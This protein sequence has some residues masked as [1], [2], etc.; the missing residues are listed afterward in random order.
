MYS[1]EVV[2]HSSKI[3]IDRNAITIGSSKIKKENFMLQ[4]EK[5]NDYIRRNDIKIGE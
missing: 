3:A 4:F 5:I 2:I 1:S